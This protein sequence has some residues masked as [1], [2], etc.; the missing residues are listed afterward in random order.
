MGLPRGSTEA[1][2]WGGM[3]WQRTFTRALDDVDEV[4]V[5][6]ACDV[7]EIDIDDVEDISGVDVD[8]LDDLK[9]IEN[10]KEMH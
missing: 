10:M 8:D 6:D 4:D 9:D 3:G 5:D 7:D 2:G 1:V